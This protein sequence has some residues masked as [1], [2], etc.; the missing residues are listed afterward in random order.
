MQTITNDSSNRGCHR[1]PRFAWKRF[2]VVLIS[3]WAACLVTTQAQ[4][5][6]TVD[7]IVAVVNDD[8]IVLQELN[9][10]L[11]PLQAQMRASGY[12]PEKQREMLYDI[13]KQILN[14]LIEQ[15]LIEQAAAGSNLTVSEEEVDA[16]LER[17]KEANKVTDE[18]FREA[19]ISQGMSM[20][21]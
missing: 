18:E 19:L 9:E 1:S 15:K 3:F 13:R 12:L 17:V 5:A 16:T 10:M 21:R 20:N 2:L 6:M 11:A 4:A 8:I 7:R 14:Q